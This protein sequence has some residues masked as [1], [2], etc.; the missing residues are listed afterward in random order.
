M[1]LVGCG[2]PAPVEVFLMVSGTPTRAGTVGRYCV[3]H[4][5]IR[6][7]QEQTRHHGRLWYLPARAPRRD[8]AGRT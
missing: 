5:V 1:W 8:R 2:Y 6:G 4:A 3:G 7:I